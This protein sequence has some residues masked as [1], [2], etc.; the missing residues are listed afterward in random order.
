MEPVK[1]CF[2]ENLSKTVQIPLKWGSVPIQMVSLL[3]SDCPSFVRF[4]T[5]GVID[6]KT[7]KPD[8]NH[9]LLQIQFESTIYN[10]VDL[11]LLRPIHLK[12]EIENRQGDTNPLQVIVYIN[13]WVSDKKRTRIRQLGL[14]WRCDCGQGSDPEKVKTLP[15]VLPC[16]HVLCM[17]CL[18]D[19]GTRI[20]C[21]KHEKKDRMVVTADPSDLPLADDVMDRM[22]RLKMKTFLTS[23]VGQK[24]RKQIEMRCSNDVGHAATHKCRRCERK[25]C[26]R[27]PGVVSCADGS[28]K[29]QTSKIYEDCGCCYRTIDADLRYICL[30]SHCSLLDRRFCCE[31]YG[32]LHHPNHTTRNRKQQ[33]E[34][35]NEMKSR[36]ERLKEEEHK[37]KACLAEI[38]AYKGSLKD[39]DPEYD[40]I[41]RYIHRLPEKKAAQ[42]KLERLIGN[43][44]VAYRQRRSV[45]GRLL[46]EMKVLLDKIFEERPLEREDVSASDDMLDRVKNRMSAV[47]LRQLKDFNFIQNLTN[48]R[49]SP[50][51]DPRK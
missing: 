42:W 4:D 40:N 33:E 8:R 49:W 31:K 20:E 15:R 12:F 46:V 38:E 34:I 39:G 51:R 26:E 47:P 5:Q 1:I 6:P 21:Q 3:T 41:Q 13:N 10:T 30:D 27:C 44:K 2:E 7:G 16:G 17:Y 22:A 32:L 48:R 35:D 37:L 43:L 24:I 45:V 23:E 18:E 19:M 14:Q 25:F 11:V 50:Y 9:L 29:H 36:L 28:P